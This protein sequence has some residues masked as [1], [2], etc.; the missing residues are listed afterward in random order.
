[1]KL[2]HIDP[3]Y[4]LYLKHSNFTAYNLENALRFLE[5]YWLS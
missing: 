1:M 5:Q 2:Q 4:L 3:N